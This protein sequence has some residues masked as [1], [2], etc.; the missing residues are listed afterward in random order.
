MEK[1]DVFTINVTFGD[2][3]L[4]LTIPRKDEELYR[5]AEK[6]LSRLCAKYRH[7]YNQKSNEELMII[8]AYHLAVA[9]K[10]RDFIEDTLPVSEKLELLGKELDE[11][12][13]EQ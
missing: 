4:P 12:L 9:L 2:W 1:N 13:K 5:N 6:L 3:R 10:K 8:S 11:L 7:K